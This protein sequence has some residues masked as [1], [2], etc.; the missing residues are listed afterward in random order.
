[1]RTTNIAESD[2]S[3]WGMAD[4]TTAVASYRVVGGP[5]K[6]FRPSLSCPNGQEVHNPA[7]C[8]DLVESALSLIQ[9]L[10]AEVSAAPPAVELTISRQCRWRSPPRQSW[11]QTRGRAAL[12]LAVAATVEPTAM[13]GSAVEVTMI[14]YEA[15]TG[16]GGGRVTGGTSPEYGLCG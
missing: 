10:G 5:R 15:E 16:G 1:L 9:S 11:L 2:R 14:G 8:R 12:R 4:V 13:E 3:H 7:P 6:R